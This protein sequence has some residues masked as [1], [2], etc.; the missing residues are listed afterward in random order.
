MENISKDMIIDICEEGK[1]RKLKEAIKEN[2][3]LNEKYED[4]V[5]LI[6][7]LI[8]KLIFKM[9]TYKNRGFKIAR[10]KRCLKYLLD[11]DIKYSNCYISFFT[12]IWVDQN[13]E[14]ADK[15]I[16]KGLDVNVAYKEYN[17]YYENIMKLSLN[18]Y[19][20]YKNKKEK[21]KQNKKYTLE[22]LMSLKQVNNMNNE[23]LLLEIVKYNHFYL[24]N[25]LINSNDI[26]KLYKETTL[27]DKILTE[28][29]INNNGTNI[30][31]IKKSHIDYK[32]C[33]DTANKACELK[34][35]RI[36]KFLKRNNFD[37]NNIKKEY[38]D[39]IN[40]MNI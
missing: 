24:L 18:R 4:D 38:Q 11:L 6:D 35:R 37:M 19:G 9:Y 25:E 7:I 23:E 27:A 30:L 39:I 22:Y 17:S 12:A 28:D 16:E 10:I 2:K 8:T 29:L 5:E 1:I 21:R 13:F 32:L 33:V 26:N 34:N 15:L 14:I 31:K 20:R 3:I 36:L 40:S